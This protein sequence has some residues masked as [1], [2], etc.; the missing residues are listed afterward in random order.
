MLVKSANS[1]QLPN[2]PHTHEEKSAAYSSIWLNG[3]VKNVFRD[4]KDPERE[5]IPIT[6][7]EIDFLCVFVVLFLF[8]EAQPEENI[9]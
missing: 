4:K 5:K 7:S 9:V 2:F 8:W 3:L 1:S 6:G